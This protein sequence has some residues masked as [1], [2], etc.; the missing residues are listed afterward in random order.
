M[1]RLQTNA[2]AISSSKSTA[3]AEVAKCHIFQGLST[4]KFQ[5]RMEPFEMEQPVEHRMKRFVIYWPS[6]QTRQITTQYLTCYP[7]QGRSSLAHPYHDVSI[8]HHE[9]QPPTYCKYATMANR[10][11]DRSLSQKPIEYAEAP[12]AP[13]PGP[14]LLDDLKATLLLVHPS[15]GAGVPLAHTPVNTVR[16]DTKAT[17]EMRER[18]VEPQSGRSCALRSVGEG[19]CGYPGVLVRCCCCYREDFRNKKTGHNDCFMEWTSVTKA[20]FRNRCPSLEEL[21]Q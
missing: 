21:F 7:R 2:T 19:G 1:S 8:N 9:R 13:G 11:G 10:N 17:Q 15:L 14:N 3:H 5:T 4:S 12:P 16:D 18:V 6:H 20:S